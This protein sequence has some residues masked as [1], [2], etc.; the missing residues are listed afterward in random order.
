MT[1]HTR[2]AEVYDGAYRRL[3]AGWTQGDMF[4]G[5]YVCLVGAIKHA[6]RGH[7]EQKDLQLDL[8][9]T[10]LN[11]SIY[12]RIFSRVAQR[13]LAWAYKIGNYP[14]NSDG[15]IAFVE[16]W[17]DRR[18][19]RKK[20]VLALLAERRDFHLT[21]AKDERIA[22]LERT[23]KRLSERL[24]ELLA[25]TERLGIEVDLLKVEVT[26]WKGRALNRKRREFAGVLQE[27]AEVVERQ[28]QNT[29][30]LWELRKP[31]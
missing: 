14:V 29:M 28:E 24:Q 2:M 9:E 15:G 6:S 19:R 27:T 10:L 31:L 5:N 1:N 3:E 26:F 13:R 23:N 4:D 16:Q 7:L 12:A 8:A 11:Q 21:L 25:E 20:R 22:S 18:F 17:N 30:E